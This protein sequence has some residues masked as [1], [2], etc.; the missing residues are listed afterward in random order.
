MSI[1]HRI[2]AIPCGRRTKW[3]VL[4]FWVVLIG[5]AGPLAGKLTDAQENDSAAWLPVNAESTQ[6]LE[7]QRAFQPDE[8]FPAVVVYE[9]TSGVMPEDIKTATD[10]AVAFAALDGVDQKPI[11]PIRSEEHTSEL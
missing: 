2:A 7:Q 4:L 11:G 8:T 9:Y 5:V 6:V 3:L 10:D 1:G